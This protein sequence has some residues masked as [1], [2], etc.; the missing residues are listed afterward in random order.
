MNVITII[1]LYIMGVI[2]SFIVYIMGVIGSF[3][4]GFEFGYYVKGEAD[5]K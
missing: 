4:V 3:I 1:I 2:G 5:G